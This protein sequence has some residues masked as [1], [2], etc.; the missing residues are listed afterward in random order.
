MVDW[1][2]E[3]KQ[4][5]YCDELEMETYTSYLISLSPSLFLSFSVLL[6][7]YPTLNPSIS[8]SFLVSFLSFV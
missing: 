7:H 5:N 8:L 3:N 6:S 1:E 2:K 4:Q